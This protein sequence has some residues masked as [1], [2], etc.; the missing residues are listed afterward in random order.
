METSAELVYLLRFDKDNKF[1][2]TDELEKAKSC[3]GSFSGTVAARHTKATLAFLPA[4]QKGSLVSP[5]MFHK[6]YSDILTT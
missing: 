6:H 4:R 2:F 3:N 5:S 1:G